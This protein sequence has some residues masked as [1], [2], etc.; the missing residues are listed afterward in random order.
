MKKSKKSKKQLKKQNYNKLIIALIV[1]FTILIVLAGYLNLTRSQATAPKS[2]DD[3]DQIVTQ[4]PTPEPAFVPYN[5]TF[6][7]VIDGETRTFTDPRY[8]NKSADVYITP[9][10]SRQVQ[11]TVAQPNITWGILFATLPMSVT[12]DCI[13]TGTQQTFCSNASKQLRFYINGVES[14]DALI[15]VI[16]PSSQLK[17][18]Y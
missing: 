4:E 5:A 13:V 6:Q 3:T 12:K 1:F 14:P 17:I 2:S 7:I 15:T 18:V 11:I 9:E 10:G 8:H 16:E